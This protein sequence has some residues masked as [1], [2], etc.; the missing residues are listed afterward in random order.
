[1]NIRL[2]FLYNRMGLSIKCKILTTRLPDFLKTTFDVVS[3]Y[4]NFSFCQAKG[5]GL[6]V[7]VVINIHIAVSCTQAACFFW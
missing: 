4:R 6:K 5:T 3:I 7:A 1:M 2:G